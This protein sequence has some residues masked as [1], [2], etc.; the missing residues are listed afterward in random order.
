MKKS[1]SSLIARFVNDERASASIVEYSIILPICLFLLALLFLAGMY[2]N[3]KAVLDASVNRGVVLAQKIYCDNNADRLM[4]LGLTDGST[5]VGVS[6]DSS[7]FLNADNLD[8]EPYR[9]L[10]FGSRFDEV[11][12]VIEKKISNSIKA[13][14]LIQND[15][16]LSDLQVDIPEEF[17]GF[18]M[19][20][21]TVSVKQEFHNPFVPK[22]L[23]KSTNPWLK[24]SSSATATVMSTTEYMRNV[25]ML[26]DILGRY[27]GNSCD[28]WVKNM[29]S[30]LT[31]F[32]NKTGES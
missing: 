28:K 22:L 29:L 6:V 16:R 3:Q 8:S 1:K 21:M 24:M 15:V 20:K 27:T 11:Y 26:N 13:S 9:Y 14:Q 31:G 30:R 2:L 19:Y 5:Q 7:K 23:G 17:K 32:M 10:K 12:S 25:D 4:N 18:V